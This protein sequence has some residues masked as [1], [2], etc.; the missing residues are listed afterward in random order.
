MEV[1]IVREY[2]IPIPEDVAEKVQVLS[3]HMGIRLEAVV[4]F[5]VLRYLEIQNW[6]L[7]LW[8]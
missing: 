8:R 6:I 5:A 7:K 4:L 1:R 3:D 2:S